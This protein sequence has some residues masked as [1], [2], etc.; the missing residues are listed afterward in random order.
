MAAMFEAFRERMPQLPS[1]RDQPQP[2]SDASVF[3]DEMTTAGFRDVEIREA[4]GT[5]DFP[6][7]AEGWQTMQ[8]TMAPLAHLA[9]K[10]GPAWPAA[11]DAIYASLVDRFGEG[12]QTV[13][14][15]AWLGVGRR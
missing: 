11:A 12:R 3:R 14:L 15:P 9:E 10:M 7:L 2:L 5:F 13:T 1:R 4:R 8:R 6:T